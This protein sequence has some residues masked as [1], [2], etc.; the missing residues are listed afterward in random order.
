MHGRV[1]T[2]HLIL[3]LQT[4]SGPVRHLAVPSASL[5]SYEGGCCGGG[6]EVVEVKVVVEVMSSEDVIVV[7]MIEFGEY[8]EEELER[9]L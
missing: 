2:H 1:Y 9:S 4:I 6:E 3:I 8:K 5:I 7:G